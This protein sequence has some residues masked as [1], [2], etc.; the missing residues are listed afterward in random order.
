[1]PSTNTNGASESKKWCSYFLANSSAADDLPWNDSYILSFPE[2]RAIQDSIQQFQLGEGS[3]GARLLKR[4]QSY[5]ADARD[6][7]FA[8]ALGSFIREEQRH[9]ACLL[10]FMQTQGIPSVTS[11]WVDSV[12]RLLR[13]L[14]G[15]ELSLRVLVTAEIIAVPYYRALGKATSSVLLRTISKMILEDEAAHLRFQA[16]MLSRLGGGRARVVQQVLSFT[17]RFFLRGTCCVVW[18]GHRKVFVAAS[19]T[20]RKFMRESLLELRAV[21]AS[22]RNCYSAEVAGRSVAALSRSPEISEVASESRG[23]TRRKRHHTELEI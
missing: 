2:R 7:D 9:S 17:H 19:Y 18:A 16:S 6:P 10:R 8:L 11:H 12:F 5:S 13:G 3:I 20:F 14:A 21:D 15:L 22:S 4:G 23:W 1:M